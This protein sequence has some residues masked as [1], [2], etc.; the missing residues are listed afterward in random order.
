M[1]A[2][3][4]IEK[5]ER[6][7]TALEALVVIRELVILDENGR[8]GGV[9]RV[10]AHRPGLMFAADEGKPRAWLRVP[11]YGPRLDVFDDKGRHR[12]SVDING[13]HVA[14]TFVD[15]E[16]KPRTEVS[17][18]GFSSAEAEYDEKGGRVPGPHGDTMRY[19][20]ALDYIG[21]DDE[22]CLGL[23][24]DKHCLSL[25]FADIGGEPRGVLHVLKDGCTLGS[26]KDEDGVRWKLDRDG[27]LC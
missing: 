5:L 16:G 17:M 18:D 4:R 21:E 11:K 2:E 10:L 12:V 20:P 3:E 25:T 14:F 24:V 22:F 1:T 8:R 9:V 6:E 15:Q 7:L 13:R 19:E 23:H 26:F 27:R